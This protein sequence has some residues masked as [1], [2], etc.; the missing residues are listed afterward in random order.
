GAPI[1]DYA[2][3][4]EDRDRDVVPRPGIDDTHG[5]A[6]GDAGPDVAVDLADRPV[7]ALDRDHLRYHAATPARAAA[8]RQTRKTWPL[9]SC[10]IPSRPAPLRIAISSLA[11]A[12]ASAVS[13][14]MSGL[15]AN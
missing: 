1:D 11:I 3:R 15:K 7:R 14:V 12:T 9:G 5:P 10:A 13:T 8:R 4:L 2:S 6:R